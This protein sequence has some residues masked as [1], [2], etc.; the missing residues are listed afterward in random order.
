MIKIAI[1][2]AGS[3]GCYLGGCLG[4]AGAQITLVGRERVLTGIRA[5]G[6]TVTDY[7]GRNQRVKMDDLTLSIHADVVKEADLILVTVKSAATQEAGQAL[8]RFARQGVPIISFQNGVSN[9]EQL[10]VLL[11]NNPV[12]AGM[13]PFNVVDRGQGRFHQGSSGELEV[14]EGRLPGDVELC[15]E[16]AN[17]PLLRQADMLAVRWGKLLLN[18][19]NPVNALSGIPLKEELSQR[20]YRCC[21][22]M[23]QREALQLMQMVGIRPAKVTA[24]PSHWL[25]TALEL[26]DW[27]FTRVAKKMLAID[28]LARSSMWEDLQA[29]RRTEI[30]WINGEVVRLAER[31]KQK[32]PVNAK[33]VELIREA[34]RPEDRRDWSG[35]ELLQ[36]LK[37]ARQ[38]AAAG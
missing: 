20:A 21:V 28:P 30:D 31:I 8:A 3:I 24:V 25:P 27:L 22:A 29:G 11:P 17:L 1:F 38:R 34:E 6:L 32:A 13:V 7:R 36:T 12:L 2:G 37:A 10:A 26:P 5:H 4:A 35:D 33:L 14:D 9:P 18:L 23:A 16:S 19:N 15:F